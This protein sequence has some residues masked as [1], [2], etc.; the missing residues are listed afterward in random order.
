MAKD[1]ENGAKKFAAGALVGALA[2]A[3][4]GLLFAPKSGKE[5]REDI[6]DAAV[7]TKA[8]AEKQLKKLYDE[9]QD[10]LLAAKDKGGKAKNWGGEE[11]A[12][13]LSAA[14]EA[15]TKVKTLLSSIRTGDTNDHDLEMAIA[16]AKKAKKHLASF[17][18]K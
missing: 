13:A 12:Q 7:H 16:E 6:K 3:I 9:L 18:K 8:Q 2:G 5:T 15:S 17:L 11:A 10:L 1:S 14:K 4:A